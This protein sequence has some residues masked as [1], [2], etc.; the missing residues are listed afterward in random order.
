MQH[1]FSPVGYLKVFNEVIIIAD[2]DSKSSEKMVNIKQ[3]KLPISS[4][5]P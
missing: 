3:K 5:D 1:G 2:S 4:T